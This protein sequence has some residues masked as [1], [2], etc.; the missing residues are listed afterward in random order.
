MNKIE[1][2]KRFESLMVQIIFD[3][4]D[5]GL[6]VV[7]D[8]KIQVKNPEK[9]TGPCYV[10]LLY[11]VEIIPMYFYAGSSNADLMKQTTK[12]YV[13]YFQSLNFYINE[14]LINYQ[15]FTD[16]QQGKN[17]SLQSGTAITTPVLSWNRDKTF[18]IKQNA[19]FDLNITAIAYQVTATMI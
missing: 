4:Q 2:L 16:I 1:D 15:V 8:G 14:Q 12:I 6:Y 3:D 13:E 11:P 7:N 9:K 19:P 5:Y 18:V 10:G 17:L